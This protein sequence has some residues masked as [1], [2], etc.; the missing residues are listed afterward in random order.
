MLKENNTHQANVL[1]VSAN[2]SD[3][4]ELQRILAGGGF[5]CLKTL[6]DTK[7]LHKII[8]EFMPDLLLLDLC[9]LANNRNQV[10]DQFRQIE[11]E[12]AIP[13]IALTKCSDDQDILQTY[14]EGALDYIKKPFLSMD[15]IKRVDRILTDNILTRHLHTNNS[16]LEKLMIRGEP[17]LE[18][19]V[20]DEFSRLLKIVTG[21]NVETGLHVRRI[22]LYV[23]KLSQI[24]GL[25]Q[26][27]SILY[28]YAS[29]LHD[30]GKI[31]IPDSVLLK[32]ETLTADET[33]LIQSHTVIGAQMLSG[34][35]REVIR[36]AEVIA[37]TH[38]ERWDGKGYP[39][40]LCGI[41]IPLSGRITAIC[42][43]YDALLSQRPYK[44]AW[45]Q[46]MAY[47]E[48]KRLRGKAF[49]PELVDLFLSNEQEFTHISRHRSIDDFID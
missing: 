19:D 44:S 37:L 47:A 10:M 14:E 31:A 12:V 29:M 43:V 42:D 41:S 1:I 20:E 46:H 15:V 8:S 22:G 16:K 25:S 2:K 13:V 36:E 28:K 33:A 23:Y 4:L 38:H 34:S 45:K 32:P 3:S 21:R 6:E 26:E 49:D 18:E 39:R 48:I 17:E 11:K 5:K 9:M 40:K 27:Y 35:N 24:K 7:Q 30:I